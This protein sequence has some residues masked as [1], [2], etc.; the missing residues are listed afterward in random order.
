MAGSTTRFGFASGAGGDAEDE[1]RAATTLYGRDL[2]LD[3]AALSSLGVPAHAPEAVEQGAAA[4]AA[5]A[6]A[7]S[8]GDDAPALTPP[9]HTGKSRFPALARLFG[10]WNTGG[11]LVEHADRDSLFEIPRPSYRRP[12]GILAVAAS[13]GFLVVVLLIRFNHHPTPARVQAPQTQPLAAPQP[14][15]PPP[16]VRPVAPAPPVAAPQAQPIAV[17]PAQPVA[18]PPE[19]RPTLKAAE[20]PRPAV[21]RPTRRRAPSSDPDSLLPLNF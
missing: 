2:H 7:E 4:P 8:P 11:D 9:E 14:P 6:A 3:R 16:A 21:R 19:A 13:V 5:E 10:R 20:P 1:A 17:P 18:A 12:L 15:Q